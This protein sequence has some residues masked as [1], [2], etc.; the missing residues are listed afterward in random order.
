VCNQQPTLPKTILIVESDDAVRLLLELT[1]RQET[2]HR[3]VLVSNYQVAL[4]RA[5]QVWPDL[6]IVSAHLLS[7][8]GFGVSAQLHTIPGL[9]TTPTLLLTTIPLHDQ[10]TP[11][12]LVVV[13]QPFELDYLLAVINRLLSNSAREKISTGR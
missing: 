3:A 8:N 10:D 11:Y 5:M 6:F 7:R 12:E 9:E 2:C 1:I 13:E 4:T